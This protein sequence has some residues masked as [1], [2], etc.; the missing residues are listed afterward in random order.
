MGA[1]ERRCSQAGRSTEFALNG[2]AKS[3]EEHMCPACIAS[4]ALIITGIISTGGLTALAAKKLHAKNNANDGG[5]FDSESRKD[6]SS[7]SDTHGK[8]E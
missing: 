8:E 2:V 6:L 7:Q 3:G 5:S 4:A 1:H